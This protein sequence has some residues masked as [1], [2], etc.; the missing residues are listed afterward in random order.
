MI[1]H[2]RLGSERTYARTI[3]RGRASAGHALKPLRGTPALS[4][5][6]QLSRPVEMWAAGAGRKVGHLLMV[7]V[8]DAGS[9]KPA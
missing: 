9:A 8:G 6:D 4:T 7:L 1:S 5:A 3:K 2:F